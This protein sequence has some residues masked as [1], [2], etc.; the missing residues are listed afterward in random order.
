MT[1]PVFR[2]GLQR[3][4]C[5]LIGQ[6]INIAREV[7]GTVG[8]LAW[9]STQATLPTPGRGCFPR[10]SKAGKPWQQGNGSN[11]RLK[12]L[13]HRIAGLAV[14][15]PLRVRR[16]LRPSPGGDCFHVGEQL[17]CTVCVHS[18]AE[19]VSISWFVQCVHCTVCTVCTLYNIVYIVHC[20]VCTL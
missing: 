18:T 19:L 13:S 12:G 14:N 9:D 8:S 5:P 3:N 1:S 16:W 7:Q 15:C 20:T 6:P 17:G 10:P 2:F 4:W 11:T